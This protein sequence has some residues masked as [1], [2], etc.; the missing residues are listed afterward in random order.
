MSTSTKGEVKRAAVV[1]A[2]ASRL[3]F[4]TDEAGQK[5]LLNFVGDHFDQLQALLTSF[6]KRGCPKAFWVRSV[7]FHGLLVRV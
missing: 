5:A 1:S 3:R 4:G 7:L 2:W 6:T